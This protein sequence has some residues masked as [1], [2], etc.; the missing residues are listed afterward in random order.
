MRLGRP[1]YAAS[2]LLKACWTLP[3]GDGGGLRASAA[4]LLARTGWWTRRRS[5]R[6]IGA[7]NLRAYADTDAVGHA[8]I[9]N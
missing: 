4:A 7:G 8:A 1:R 5:L 2:G 3:S 6:P 9:S